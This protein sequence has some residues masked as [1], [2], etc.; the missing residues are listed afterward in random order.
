MRKR[1]T[2]GEKKIFKKSF[3]IEVSQAGNTFKT[4]IKTER[5]M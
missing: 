4:R 1:E 3:S 5:I 2:H